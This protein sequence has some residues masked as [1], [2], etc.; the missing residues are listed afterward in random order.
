MASI[1]SPPRTPIRRSVNTGPD[2]PSSINSHTSTGST[3]ELKIKYSLFPPPDPPMVDNLPLLLAARERAIS[4]A[5]S[6][7]NFRSVSEGSIASDSPKPNPT[8]K[9]VIKFKRDR[10]VSFKLH[11]K[12]KRFL[13]K[14]SISPLNIFSES[15]CGVTISRE[16][17]IKTI[18]SGYSS[19]S[20]IKTDEAGPGTIHAH[21]ISVMG[22]RQ[23]VI[24]RIRSEADFA[25]KV[26]LMQESPTPEKDGDSSS[27]QRADKTA[28]SSTPSIG[29]PP[30]E[31]PPDPTS[32]IHRIQQKSSGKN[33]QMFPQRDDS[34]RF[35]YATLTNR[36]FPDGRGSTEY[37]NQH[38][39]NTS[40]GV[41]TSSCISHAP[42]QQLPFVGT[43]LVVRDSSVCGDSFDASMDYTQENEEISTYSDNEEL[44]PAHILKRHLSFESS[45]E[46]EAPDLTHSSID[47]HSTA[48]QDHTEGTAETPDE[49]AAERSPSKVTFSVQ[50][51]S[52]VE[53]DRDVPRGILDNFIETLARTGSATPIGHRSTPQT[54]P[55]RIPSVN[56]NALDPLNLMNIRREIVSTLNSE[57]AVDI[58][59]TLRLGDLVLRSLD[60]YTFKVWSETQRIRNQRE[61]LLEKKEL[62]YQAL[63]KAKLARA[64]LEEETRGLQHDNQAVLRGSLRLVNLVGDQ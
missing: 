51:A 43:G 1:S 37:S 46:G 57:N 2:S 58:S 44:L 49:P 8:I 25:P 19:N 12:F 41:N 48:S 61:V 31:L 18:S 30:S 33:L 52:P 38:L 23:K 27:I 15:E 7:P 39:L 29:D 3:S 24:R 21:D 14:K 42:S 35:S 45:A 55:R 40:R 63:D 16:D 36:D 56:S 17:S 34:L 22:V 9:D 47:S 6:V 28:F 53:L 62:L 50:S 60:S 64:V 32:Q 11:E 13:S 5:K 54:P 20:A 26:S 59:T 4:N 10:S